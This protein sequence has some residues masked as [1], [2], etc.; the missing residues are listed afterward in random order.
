[1]KSNCSSQIEGYRQSL[2]EMNTKLHILLDQEKDDRF[3]VIIEAYEG[4]LTRL[5]LQNRNL[6]EQNNVLIQLNKQQEMNE[7]GLDLEGSNKLKEMIKVLNL[8]LIN[9]ENIISKYRFLER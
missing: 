6:R 9:K 7:G 8:D 2:L 1:M 4:D 3:R 5:E